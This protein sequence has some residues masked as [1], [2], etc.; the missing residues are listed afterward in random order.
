M[1]TGQRGGE[2]YKQTILDTEHPRALERRVFSQVTRALEGVLVSKEKPRLSESDQEALSRNQQLWGS[3]MF[4]C[5]QP[6]N[7]LPDSLKAGVIS[8]A[9]FVDN[10]T[11]EVLAGRKGV[12]PLVAINRNV[13]LGLKGAAPVD[14]TAAPAAAAG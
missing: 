4:D 10:Y 8:L 12:D 1:P 7:P 9:I 5:M 14:Q 13:I 3:L 6:E 2:A 11:G